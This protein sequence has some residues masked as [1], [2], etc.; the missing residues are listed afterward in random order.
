VVGTC[1]VCKE[2]EFKSPIP[3]R[4]LTMVESDIRFFILSSFLTVIETLVN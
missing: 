4:A 3:I 1:V 2:Q